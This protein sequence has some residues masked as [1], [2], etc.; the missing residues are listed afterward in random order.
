[1]HP[2]LNEMPYFCPWLNKWGIWNWGVKNHFFN[3]RPERAKLRSYIIHKFCWISTKSTSLY[4]LHVYSSLYELHVYSKF[5]V[6]EY[7]ELNNYLDNAGG[8]DVKKQ[9]TPPKV[10]LKFQVV[11]CVNGCWLKQLASFNTAYLRLW[12]LY[13]STYRHATSTEN[14]SL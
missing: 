2:H 12:I 1:M 13:S 8:K 4:E 3:V 11:S 5:F 9:C 10:I 14:V 6:M 7:F